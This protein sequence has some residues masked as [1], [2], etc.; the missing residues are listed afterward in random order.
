M[1]A[2]SVTFGRDGRVRYMRKVV[3]TYERKSGEFEF[4]GEWY[5]KGTVVTMDDGTQL[6]GLSDLHTAR[7]VRNV[8]RR[9]S[10]PPVP[11]QVLAVEAY[12]DAVA[13]TAPDGATVTRG[14]GYSDAWAPTVWAEDKTQRWLLVATETAR[15]AV[16][17]DF[18]EGGWGEPGVRACGHTLFKDAEGGWRTFSRRG[19]EDSFYDDGGAR[20]ATLLGE[21][22]E[23]AAK[24]SQRSV[25]NLGK[26]ITIPGAPSRLHKDKLAEAQ[27]KL[28][29]GGQL[30]LAPSGFGTAMVISGKP[31]RGF[32]WK[33]NPA[34][35]E[36][37]GVPEAYTSTADWD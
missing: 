8:L 12:L 19:I 7:D 9:R 16:N 3:G 31:M 25:D 29:R 36:A 18:S 4:G 32:G 34:V 37:L 15:V 13:A 14:E 28:R 11:E 35:A 23:R 24:G 30:T 1:K 26:W 10:L 20:A 33:R 17:A 21:Q 27:A 5:D 6:A 2:E 22:L